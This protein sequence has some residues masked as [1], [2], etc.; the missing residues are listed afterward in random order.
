MT[1]PDARGRVVPPDL[2]DRRWDDLVAE[3]VALI[4]RYAPQW[5]DHQ[6][7]DLGITLVELFAWLVE[8]LI[9]RLN[10]VPEKTHLAFL[11]L[12]GLT[13][14]P[15][16]PARTVLTF[17]ARPG[18]NG[19]SVP[20]GTRAQTRPTEAHVPVAVETERDCRLVPL[21]PRAALQVTEPAESAPT[22]ERSD[23]VLDAAAPTTVG[24]ALDPGGSVLVVLGL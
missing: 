6:P 20:A 8:G 17:S 4:P 22:F 1:A 10:R 3:A 11:E 16:T 13:R 14:G 24:V 9:Y 2:D 21:V 23:E 7:G 15:R 18:G 5:T 12:L 19:V